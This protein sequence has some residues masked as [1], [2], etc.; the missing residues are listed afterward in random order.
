MSSLHIEEMLA[1]RWPVEKCAL[2]PCAIDGKRTA[3]MQAR[4]YVLTPSTAKRILALPA[5]SHLHAITDAARRR[6]L[7]TCE[8][9]LLGNISLVGQV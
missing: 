3:A 7:N 9:H 1:K 5:R 4:R 6:A 2:G 8:L